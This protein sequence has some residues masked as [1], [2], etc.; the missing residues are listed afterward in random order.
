VGLSITAVAASDSTS[1][2]SPLEEMQMT[3][4]EKM[5]WLCEQVDAIS[6]SSGL[7]WSADGAEYKNSLYR[8]RVQDGKVVKIFEV[9][10]SLVDDMTDSNSPWPETKAKFR[11]VIENFLKA[12][13]VPKA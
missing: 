5:K 6:R 3:P 10:R 2:I 7:D 1:P 13:S 9:D 8:V 11:A 4:N 12:K